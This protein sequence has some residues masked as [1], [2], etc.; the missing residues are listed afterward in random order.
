[1]HKGTVRT[2]NAQ[3]DDNLIRHSTQALHCAVTDTII[4]L[5]GC[6]GKCASYKDILCKQSLPEYRP[7]IA[8]GHRKHT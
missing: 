6:K 1:M 4:P 2:M 3:A 5:S 7:L 8:R